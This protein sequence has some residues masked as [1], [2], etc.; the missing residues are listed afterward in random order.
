[1]IEAIVLESR[2]RS[3]YLVGD[4][5]ETIYFGGGSPSLLDKEEIEQILA[6][7]TEQF[8]V[9][10][11]AEITLE[12]NPDDLDPEKLQMLKEAGVNRLSIGVQSFREEDLRLMNRAHN[13]EQ[14][15]SCLENAKLAGFENI[16]MDLIYGIPGLCN[17]DW[18]DNLERFFAFDIPHLSAY[19]LTVEPKTALAHFIK[20]GSYA[21]PDEVQTAEQFEIL[22]ALCT[23]RG[24]E[25][26]EISNLALPGWRSSHNGNYWKG[27][28]YLGLGPSAHSFDGRNL[29][30]W[31]VANNAKYVKALRSGENY[32]ESE[33]LSTEDRI[34]EYLMTGLRTEAGCDLDWI[35][36]E[37]GLQLR[38]QLIKAASPY[39][40]TGKLMVKKNALK[41]SLQGKLVSDR[42][43]SDLFIV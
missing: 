41:L 37:F 36:G 3:D 14:A 2:Q 19:A 39:L 17:Q 33:R 5:V 21:A 43:I 18:R 42:I 20:T 4:E 31:N 6:A 9:N 1:M 29:R 16:T 24:Y 13:S 15:H 30:R 40:E 25:H 35:E 11:L 8:Q 23:E 10:G 38:Q 32:F 7:L 28:K 34:N 22:S 26:Y 27:V 12:A